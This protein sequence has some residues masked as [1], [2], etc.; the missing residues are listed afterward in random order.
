MTNTYT[1]FL[2]GMSDRCFYVCPYPGNSGDTLIQMGTAEILR[3]LGIQTTLVP[4]EADVVL[5]PGGNPTMWPVSFEIWRDAW[6]RMPGKP[7]IVG[8]VT[9]QC[10]FSQVNWIEAVRQEG[11]S[12]TAMFA[13]DQASFANLSKADLPPSIKIGLSDDPALY[14]RESELIAGHRAGA[15][16]EYN[17]FAFRSDREGTRLGGGLA[18]LAGILLPRYGERLYTR[19]QTRQS[20]KK[21]LADA[22]AR[23]PADAVCKVCDAACLNIGMFIETLKRAKH[24]H[25]DRLHTMI[26]A[27]MLNKKVFAYSTIFRKLEAVYDFSMKT[28]ADVTFVTEGRQQ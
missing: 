25:T 8:P 24:V 1:D 28:W 16:E 27:A 4:A 17:L 11:Q 21:K 26:L 20:R 7:F 2:R 5:C 22:R 18:K 6:R 15:T 19:W 13:R 3:T 10:Q 12:V 9:F 23:E 14:L